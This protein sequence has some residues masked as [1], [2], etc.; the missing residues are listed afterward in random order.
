[1]NA[2]FKVTGMEDIQKALL[3]AC[4]GAKAKRVRKEAL[5][6]GADVIVEQMKANFDP[7]KDTGYSRDEIMRTDARTKNDIEELKIGWNGEHGRWRLVHLNEFGYTKM[8]KQYTPRGFG[9]IAKSLTE[10]Q[11]GFEQEVTRRMR[12]GL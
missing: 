5:N 12:E 8:G 10:A 4:S 3:E 1:M 9:A 2:G 6:S 11:P 7:F